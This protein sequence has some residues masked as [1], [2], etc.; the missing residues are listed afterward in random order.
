MRAGHGRAGDDAGAQALARHF[1][2]AELAD[3][4]D[5]DAGAILLDRIAQ[6]LFDIAIV[7][8]VFHVDE[9]DDDQAGEVAQPELAADFVG[10]F[11][12]G[13]ARGLLDGMFARGAARVHVDR[14]QRLG[15]VDDDVAARFQR[16]GG[17]E[18]RIELGF[19]M[20]ALEQRNGVVVVLDVAAHGVGISMRMKSL[21]LR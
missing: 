7:A 12:I 1:H 9:V 3:L 20:H 17:R 2:Q 5:L 8:A 10:G 15:L 18:H 6:A 4:A 16:H 11:Q 19:D 21:A 14:D 13:L